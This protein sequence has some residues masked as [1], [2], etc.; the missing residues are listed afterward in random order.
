MN[1]TE[2]NPC[3]NGA[4]ILMGGEW[5]SNAY[6]MLEINTPMKKN[7]TECGLRDV[8]IGRGDFK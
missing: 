7:K 5:I 4:Y 3:L 2:Q 1:E 8:G 6:S